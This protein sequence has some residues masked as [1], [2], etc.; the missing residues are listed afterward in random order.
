MANGYE[1]PPFGSTSDT[2][3]GW[4]MEAEQQRRAGREAQ[5]PAM[6]WEQVLRNLSGPPDALDASGGSQVSYR[7]TKRT[8][9][10]MVASLGQFQHYG[11]FTPVWNQELYDQAKVLTALDEN[12]YRNTKVRAAHRAGLQYAVGL[13]TA[14]YLQTW[15][16]TFHGRARGDISLQAI[17]PEHV[18]FVQ[19]PADHD[20]QKAYAVIWREE[21]PINLAR[22]KYAQDNPAFAA[23]LVPD[24]E[25]AGWIG[26]GLKRVQQFVAPALR[27][28]GRMSNQDQGTFPTVDIFHMWTLD[29][30]YNHG[31]AP[32][33]MGA[34]DTNWEYTVPYLGQPLPQA[35]INPQTGQPFTVPATPND[36]LMFPLRRYT[37]FSRTGVCYDGSSPY[38][39]GQVPMARLR[40]GDWPWE[41]LGYSQAADIISLEQGIV[42]TM[43]LI[44]DNHAA[45]LDPPMVFDDNVVSRSW[46]EAMSG[47]KAGQRAAA[48]LQLGDPMKPL[49]TPDYYSV[50][51]DIYAY[52][53]QQEGRMD[54]LS[55]VRDMV[56]IAKAQQVSGADALEKLLEM[57]GPIVQELVRGVSDPLVELGEMRKALF[58]Q[59]YTRARMITVAGPEGVP[60][61]DL[62]IP[63]TLVPNLDKVSPE[64]G[65]RLAHGLI[66]QFAYEVTKS[67]INDINRMTQRL[68]YF[69]LAKM[70][71]FPLSWWSMASINQIPN[72][73][74][75]PQGTNNEIERWVA[76]KEMEMDLQVRL[77]QRMQMATGGLNG[78]MGGGDDFQ[79]NQA[80]PAA[81]GGQAGAGRPQSFQEPPRLVQKDGGTRSTVTTSR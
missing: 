36:C 76:Q 44:E 28:A 69:Q 79:S 4:C 42:A 21:L 50:P 60:I 40:F 41:A 56:A 35:Q 11:E 57:A 30:A 55:G 47:R 23:A 53:E 5:Y 34:K 45:R 17:S 77:A 2:I 29:G 51:G 12:W 75:T 78:S 68:M 37:I 65:R 16:R 59:F 1:I 9:R 25:Q 38:W 20:I 52:I 10:E 31:G 63:E 22:R 66:E 43:R 27:V 81:A 19:L 72:F 46:A 6:N 74:P 13:G 26:K 18:S 71:N 73:G 64:E 48:N 49:L 70:P 32:I 33:R 3:H 62:F 39:H 8:I 67:G 61:S 58:L 15:D 80:G 54:Y 7:R 24:R 14:Y